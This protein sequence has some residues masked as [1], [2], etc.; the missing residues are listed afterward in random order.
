MSYPTKLFVSELV[1][2][3]A[4]AS[5]FLVTARS[6]RQ[7]RHGEDF[8]CVT[9]MDRTGSIEARAWEH[10]QVLAARFR[11]YDIVMTHATVTRYQDTLQLKVHDLNPLANEAV[12]LTDYMPSSRWGPEALFAQLKTLVLDHVRSPAVLALLR[13]LLSQDALMELFKRSPAATQN[14]HSYLSGLLEHAL[15]MARL[16]ISIASHYERYYPGLLDRDLVI[17]GCLLHDMGKCY[18]LSSAGGFAYTTEGKLVGHITQGVALLDEVAAC[19]H[20]APPPSLLLQLKHLILSHHGRLDY[21]SPV[22][23]QTPE[24]MVLHQLDMMDSRMNMCWNAQQAATTRE[25]ERWS[26]HHRA[27][28][29]RVYFGSEEEAQWRAQP[30]F[31]AHDLAG[32]GLAYQD[33]A[34]RPAT[35]ASLEARAARPRDAAD[36]TLNLFGE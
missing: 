15:S 7:T 31:A 3:T 24:A 19:M 30:P 26:E 27:L 11:E 25:G 34:A 33:E 5:P 14:H 21:G 10:A 9:L 2:D 6:I 8:L 13:A 18:E 36:T 20:P 32:P 4:I 17:A 29:T 22:K 28:E 1:Q 16:A 23:P 12:E 35:T